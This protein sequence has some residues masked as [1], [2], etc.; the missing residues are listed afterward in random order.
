[1]QQPLQGN[2]DDPPQRPTKVY[3]SVFLD[4][5]LAVDDKSYDFE[6]SSLGPGTLHSSKFAHGTGT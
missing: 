3:I 5:L 2:S 4:R 1:M 6:V